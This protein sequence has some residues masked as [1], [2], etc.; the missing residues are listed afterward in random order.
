[1]PDIELIIYSPEAEETQKALSDRIS[2]IHADAILRR[3]KDLHFP[4]AQK[5]ALLNDIIHSIKQ[6]NRE[7]S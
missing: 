6:R 4:T 2:N 1:M 3:I 5:Q 7:Q